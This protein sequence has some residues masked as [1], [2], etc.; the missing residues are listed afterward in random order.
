MNIRLLLKWN[1]SF[2]STAAK[3]LG[4]EKRTKKN[5]RFMNTF[6]KGIWRQIHSLIVV[7]FYRTTSAESIILDKFRVF[8]S[9]FISTGKKFNFAFFFLG[10][11]NSCVCWSAAVPETKTFHCKHEIAEHVC[12]LAVSW[13]RILFSQL[14]RIY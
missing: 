6:F 12:L 14:F 5:S 10:K 1:T 13:G 9:G 7:V 2:M 3:M 8:V 11:E 4:S